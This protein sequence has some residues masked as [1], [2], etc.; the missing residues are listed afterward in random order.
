[1]VQ[2]DPNLTTPA[3]A[4]LLGVDKLHHFSAFNYQ[5]RDSDKIRY[6]IFK[7]QTHYLERLRRPLQ[8]LN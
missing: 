1:M 6:D 5:K 4:V 2:C 7:A 3:K 8:T